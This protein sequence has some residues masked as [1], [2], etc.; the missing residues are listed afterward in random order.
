MSPPPTSTQPTVALDSL[1]VVLH[2]PAE[3]EALPAPLMATQPTATP[4]AG[5]WPQAPS[6]EFEAFP[7]PL[8][9]TQPMPAPTCAL[10]HLGLLDASGSWLTLLEA[11]PV[12]LTA[13]HPAARLKVVLL[14]QL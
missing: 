10:P 8:M 11:S 6:T 9:A 13:K 4:D 3:L 5:T 7:A 12:P 1:V 2:E 14:P